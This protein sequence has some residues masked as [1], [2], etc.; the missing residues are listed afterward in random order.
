VQREVIGVNAARCRPADPIVEAALLV[1]RELWDS[2]R[3][4][5][6]DGEDVMVLMSSRR[7]SPGI[8]DV[9][10]TVMPKTAALAGGPVSVTL[11]GSDSC[12]AGRLDDR[13]C[14]VIHGV[15]D[16]RYR[17]DM[18]RAPERDRVRYG[19]VLFLPVD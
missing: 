2:T 13:G 6:F 11:T 12:H 10:V 7:D 16:G 5:V 3:A 19:S 1:R 18:C 8:S 14:C 15:P 4:R 9:W 17:I